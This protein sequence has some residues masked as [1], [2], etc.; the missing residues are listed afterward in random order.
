MQTSIPELIDLRDESE[1]VFELYGPD[2]RRA[3]SYAANCIL[4]R[5]MAERGVRFIQLFHPDWDHH[6]FSTDHRQQ[7]PRLQEEYARR[8]F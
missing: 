2:S 7:L 4:A 5:R 1:E 3:G 8:L 6:R